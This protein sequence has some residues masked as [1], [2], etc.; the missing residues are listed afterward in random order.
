MDL[1]IAG[2]DTV[3]VENVEEDGYQVEPEED[4]EHVAPLFCVKGCR[5]S[6]RGKWLDSWKKH[7]G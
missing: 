6:E 7:K 5:L 1:V 4:E 3:D 2:T